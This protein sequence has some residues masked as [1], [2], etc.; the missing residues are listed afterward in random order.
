MSEKINRQDLRKLLFLFV[1]FTFLSIPVYTQDIVINEV[2]VSNFKT[3]DW[4][5]L[6]NQSGNTI[7]LKGYR[8]SDKNDYEHVWPFPDTVILP[9]SHL[10]VFASGENRYNSIIYYTLDGLIPNIHSTKYMNMP[11]HISR[12]M[13]VRANRDL[14]IALLIQLKKEQIY[15]TKNRYSVSDCSIMNKR[16]I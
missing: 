14:L 12:T 9:H 3:P 6:Y 13:V 1:W 8:I 15:R 11:I 2:M 7:H 4:I 5:E 16:E 10:T